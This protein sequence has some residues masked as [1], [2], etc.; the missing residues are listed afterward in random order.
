MTETAMP[1]PAISVDVISDVVCPWCFLGLRRLE[2]AIDALPDTKVAVR[3]R[4]YQLDPTIPP[5][6]VDRKAYMLGK[7]G[8]EDRIRPIHD[9]LAE[10]GRAAGIAFDFDAIAVAP[11]TL[12]AHRVLRWAG[13]ES[14]DLQHR[15]QKR[16]M[17]DYFEHGRN[18]GDP[19]VLA[20]AASD[21]GMDGSVVATLLA[22]DADADAV[23][24]EM[25]T[26]QRMGVTGVPCFLL[27]ERYALMGAQDVETLAGAISQIATAKQRGELDPSPE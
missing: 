11:N 21:L 7:F 18:I 1:S 19:A 20:E 10:M 14:D 6:G 17:S 25:E 22:T 13:A 8:S 9:R 15:L 26:A 27:E 5:Q 4:P 12:N 23:R 16:L 24:T 2:Q 3:W